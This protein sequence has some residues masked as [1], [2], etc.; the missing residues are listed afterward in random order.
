MPTVRTAAVLLAL[1]ALASCAAPAGPEPWESFF[2]IQ[3]ADTQLAFG[4]YDRNVK[5]YE[6]AIEHLDAHIQQNLLPSELRPQGNLTLPDM[7]LL[8][9]LNHRK[10]NHNDGC[11]KQQG[12]LCISPTLQGGNNSACNEKV[13]RQGWEIGV[14]VSRTL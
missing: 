12:S 10:T 9:G 7:N 5:N 3:M 6:R 4:D 1:G 8:P 13:Y 11:A 2:F 14:P